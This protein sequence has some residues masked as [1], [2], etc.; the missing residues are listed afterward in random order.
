MTRQDGVVLGDIAKVLGLSISTVSRALRD[1]PGL[2]SA[3]KERVL[4]TASALGYRPNLAARS[5]VSRRLLRIAVITPVEIRSVYDLVRRGIQEEAEAFLALGVELVPLIFPRLGEGD[6]SAFKQALDQDVDGIIVVPGA[7]HA[8]RASFRKAAARKIPVI[9]LLTG[10][11]E[12]ETLST[13]APNSRS[14]GALAGEIMGRVL[15]RRATVAVT[16]GDL[17]I[18]DH[19]EKFDAFRQAILACQSDAIIHP[20]LENH[21][22]ETKAYEQTRTLL[23]TTPQLRGLYISTGNG[24]PVLR[25]VEDASL[26]GSL[27]IFSTN[28]FDEVI[29][30]LRGGTVMGTLYERPYSHGQIAFRLL[31]EFLATGELPPKRV[32]LE[33]LLLMRG[34]LD[35]FLDQAKSSGELPGN[36]LPHRALLDARLH[37]LR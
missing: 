37:H 35:G 26:A 30:R 27:T 3:T 15:P 9:C 25:A 16:T 12:A 34:N 33:P 18:V 10:A 31:Y 6:R 14:C 23:K 7:L 19:Q 4:A 13:V 17:T 29:P 5:L 20:A 1:H 28:L 21:E 2:T 32:S 24:A 22:S 8:L 11:P 36:D